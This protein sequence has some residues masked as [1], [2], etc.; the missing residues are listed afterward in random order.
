MRIPPRGSTT[1]IVALVACAVVGWA[2]CAALIGVGRQFFSM[3]TTLAIH[4][5]GAPLGFGAISF[6]Y[7]RKFLHARP[8][9]TGIAF[10]G[11]VVALDLLVVAVFI[12]R[13]FAM[14]R[15]ALGTWLP[16][17]LI[18]AATYSA[19]QAVRRSRHD[20]GAP[21]VGSSAATGT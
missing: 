18:F 7:H 4:A 16:L 13:S 2:Y 9:A 19:G 1:S 20:D 21:S 15:S 11:I 3:E 12:E 10:L 8:V 5:V 14:F 6:F 17:L